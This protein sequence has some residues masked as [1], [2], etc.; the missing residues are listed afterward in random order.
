VTIQCDQPV[1]YKDSYLLEVPIDF[2]REEL[3]EA[4]LTHSEIKSIRLRSS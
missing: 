3:L 1:I 4:F 2:A